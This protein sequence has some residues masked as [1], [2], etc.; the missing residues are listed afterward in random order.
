M[1]VPTDRRAAIR[2]L[3]RGDGRPLAAPAARRVAGYSVMVIAE[4]RPDAWPDVQVRPGDVEGI[5]WTTPRQVLSALNQL[6]ASGEIVDAKGVA[7]D[8]PPSV[9]GLGP[10]RDE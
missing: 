10:K 2:V 6:R 9:R 3:L 7:G 8:E 4:A 5:L 1:S